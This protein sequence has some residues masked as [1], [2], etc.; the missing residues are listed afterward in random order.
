MCV[1]TIRQNMQFVQT[2]DKV[3]SRNK[4]C[5]TTCAIGCLTS[6]SAPWLSVTIGIL[7][8]L[9]PGSPSSVL[10]HTDCLGCS[11]VLCFGRGNGDC[12]LKFAT[13]CDG[14]SFG[15]ES[16]ACSGPSGVCISSIISITT[17]VL[18]CMNVMLQFNVPA[19]F[20]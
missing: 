10:S 5:R 7:P 6:F 19:R 14:S 11:H 13:P 16:K 15:H 17:A 1:Q 18:L 8:I 12:K 9:T 20:R 2:T 4:L 3:H